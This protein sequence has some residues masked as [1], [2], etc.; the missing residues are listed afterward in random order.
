MQEMANVQQTLN[1]INEV[2]LKGASA[3]IDTG[4]GGFKPQIPIN[5]TRADAYS[6]RDQRPLRVLSLGEY[7]PSHDTI[8]IGSSSLKLTLSLFKTG[9]VSEASPV[10]SFYKRSWT[11]Q[12]PARSRARSSI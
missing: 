10:S 12:L 11:R 2:N 9:V 8:A 3:N 5:M 4:N 1:D 7:K 6:G